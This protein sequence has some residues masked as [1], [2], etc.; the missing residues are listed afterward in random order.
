VQDLPYI[1]NVL[2]SNN[3]LTG[4]LPTMIASATA[5]TTFSYLK[6]FEFD[7]NYIYGTIPEWFFTNPKVSMSLERLSLHSNVISGT[8][9]TTIGTANISSLQYLYL[10]NNQLSGM[11]LKR[12]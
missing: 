7:T 10:H 5:A 12:L 3:S 11:Q 6:T 8:V 2:L 9:P 4:T 1:Q